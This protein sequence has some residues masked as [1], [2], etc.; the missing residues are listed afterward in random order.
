M[1]N[2]L[3]L[4]IFLLMTGCGFSSGLY[5]DIINAQ[6]L[7]TE[8]KFEK[9]AEV[10]E[11]IL[12]KKPSKTIKIKIKFQLG[13]IYSIYLSDYKKSL[14]HFESIAYDSN[15]PSWQVQSLEKIG[16]I[17]FESLKDYTKS[18]EAYLKLV[19]F[20]PVLTNQNFYRLRYAQSI[21]HQNKFQKVIPIFKKL[22]DL[23]DEDV[24]AESFNHLG[25]SYFYLG[26]HDEAIKNWLEYLKRIKRTDKIVKT[27]FLIANAYESSEKLKE[28]YN[29]Y[30]SILGEYPNTEVIKN[31]LNSLYERRVNR[32]R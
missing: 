6:N 9:A 24:V 30:Y 16:N 17:Y 5:Q 3:N 29:I 19:N 2:K 12:L 20:S 23:N 26:K 32:K 7:I 15:E 10:Y 11:A 27:K 13:D 18:Q 4:L 14:K 21:Y 8:Q 25:L 22:T 1:K 28:A 31:R